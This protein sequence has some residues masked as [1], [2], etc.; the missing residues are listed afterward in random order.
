MPHTVNGV[1]TSI[2][3]A[4]GFTRHDP[5]SPPNYDA[6]ICFTFFFMPLIPLRAVHTYGWQGS[7]YLEVPIRWSPGLVLWAFARRWAL[8]L[9]FFGVCFGIGVASE[10]HPA[11]APIGLIGMSA[12]LLLGGLALLLGFPKVDARDRAIRSL[13]GPH[14]LGTSDPATWTEKVVKAYPLSMEL[15]GTPTDSAAVPA[16]LEKKQYAMAMFAARLTIAREDRAGGEAL[17][18]K[19]LHD[20]GAQAALKAT[21]QPTGWS[22]YF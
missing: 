8:A 22:T 9:I 13:I 5:D 18:E 4:R 15:F 11:S 3:P 20:P 1:G 6:V 14:R 19:V 12:V 7:R 21:N 10:K 16:L 17:T 2:C